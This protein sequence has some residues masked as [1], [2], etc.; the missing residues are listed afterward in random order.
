MITHRVERKRDRL[1]VGIDLELGEVL[2][3]L[4]LPEVPAEDALYARLSEYLLQHVLPDVFEVAGIIEAEGET[5]TVKWF[6]D[7]R[8]Y[9]FIRSYDNTDVFVHYSGIAGD[10]YKSLVKGQAVRFK[11]REGRETLEAFEVVPLSGASGE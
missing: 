1:R 6:D 2:A 8:G 10:G 5:G 9:G 3:H 11:R 4:P 7:R